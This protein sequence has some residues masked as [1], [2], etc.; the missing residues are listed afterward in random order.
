MN[1][2]TKRDNGL[3]VV[4]VDSSPE[5]KEALRFALEEA[6]LRQATLRVV[7][8]WQ[9]GYIGAAG[10]EGSSPVVGGDLSELRHTAALALDATL[11]EVVPHSNGVVIE[12]RVVEGAP[13]AVLVEES[14]RADLLVVGSRGHGGFAGTLAWVGQPAVRGPCVMSSRD[15][16]R[17]KGSRTRQSWTCGSSARTRHRR[18]PTAIA[19]SST[20]SGLAASR[21]SKCAST[22]GPDELAP[23]RE[24]RQWFGHDPARFA[25]FR[26]RYRVELKAEET[27]LQELRARAHHGTLTLVYGARDTEHNDAVVLADLLGR[28]DDPS[29]ASTRGP[30]GR[31]A[32]RPTARPALPRGRRRPCSM[33]RRR[34]RGSDL[35]EWL[36]DA[37]PGWRAMADQVAKHLVTLGVAP[38]GRVRSL[39]RDIPLNWVP[40]GW[41]SADQA[42]LL[43]SIVFESW[44]GG[45]TIGGR[46]P[47]IRRRSV[48]STG[49]ARGWRGRHD[50]DFAPAGS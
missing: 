4:G 34:R 30:R 43:V 40:D 31:R 11:Y 25:E 45:R 50:C 48:C 10:I 22:S 35:A 7:H 5:A 39:A 20:G 36:A 44:R 24:L 19:C 6:K 41:L 26:R 9:F 29:R 46:R 12:R 18:K 47:S 15:R 8:A 33:G 28:E 1:P 21:A 42:R 38:D 23:S 49:C 2:D 14:R 17:G 27:K 13:A 32:A 16:P 37:A 3:I